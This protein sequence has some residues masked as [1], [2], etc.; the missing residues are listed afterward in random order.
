MSLVSDN[1]LNN[2]S[3]KS[4]TTNDFDPNDDRR[5]STRTTTAPRNYAKHEDGESDEDDSMKSPRPPPRRMRYRKRLAS[6]DSFVDDDDYD[7]IARKREIVEY[8]KTTTARSSI[9]DHL[10]K[11]VDDEHGESTENKASGRFN[12]RLCSSSMLI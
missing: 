3:A 9:T 11:L 10:K 2:I 8:S 7:R 12:D 4:E 6:D 1:E 5:R